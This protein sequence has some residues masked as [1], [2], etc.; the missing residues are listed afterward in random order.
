MS[1]RIQVKTTFSSTPRV[2][3]CDFWQIRDG[4]LFLFKRRVPKERG[5]PH[6]LLMAYSPQVWLTARE[7]EEYET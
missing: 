6:F 3:E 5:E 2:M 7:M 4:G 1:M